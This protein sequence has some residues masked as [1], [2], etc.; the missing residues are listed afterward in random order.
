MTLSPDGRYLITNNANGTVYV[1]DLGGPPAAPPL[2]P[3]P[4]PPAVKPPEPVIFK[5][6]PIPAEER[7]DWQPKELVAVF[8]SHKW[9]HWAAP[10]TGVQTPL[11]HFREDSRSL[12]GIHLTPTVIYRRDP[13]TG[14]DLGSLSLPGLF[15]PMSVPNARA[16]ATLQATANGFTASV[17][18]G[19]PPKERLRVQD[20]L[21]GPGS[22][23]SPVLSPGGGLL[24]LVYPDRIRM[25]DVAKERELGPLTGTPRIPFAISPDD[26]RLAAFHPGSGAEKPATIKVFDL[27][28]GQELMAIP[29][30]LK[31]P[32]ALV[33]SPD[34]QLLALG[35]DGFQFVRTVKVW[36]AATGQ[37]MPPLQISGSKPVV[38]AWAPDGNTLALGD[39]HGSIHLCDARTGKEIK[40]LRRPNP[41]GLYGSLAFSP[42]GKR[43]AAATGPDNGIFVWDIGTGE[44]LAKPEPRV[45][46]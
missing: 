46:A 17:W 12:V 10:L 22:Y 8:G 5:A 4:T 44:L 24:A 1:L 30:D 2:N 39:D 9:R 16:F 43:L 19:S 29:C 27:T 21:P 36:D 40:I 3:D 31:E 35:P 18:E 7:F 34:G 32:A 33:F 15:G 11:L 26:K 41:S 13:E 42:D 38:L 28:T 25:W 14:K 23:P 6:A 37:E 20:D 45:Q